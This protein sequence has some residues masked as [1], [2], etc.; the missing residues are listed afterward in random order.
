M[1]CQRADQ[2]QRS[3]GALKLWT[4]DACANVLFVAARRPAAHPDPDSDI[5]PEPVLAVPV[6]P[7][8]GGSFA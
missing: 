5:I 1:A 4:P 3:T 2:Y 7:H 6:E 8:L